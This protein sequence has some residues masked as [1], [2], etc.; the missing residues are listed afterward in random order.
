MRPSPPALIEGLQRIAGGAGGGN[1]TGRTAGPETAVEPMTVPM[2]EDARARF[3]ALGDEITAEL[4][5]AAGT[6]QTPILA[7]IA[8]NAAKVALVLAVGRDAVQPVI[9]LEDAV[10]AI[11]FVRHFARRTIDA[12]ERHVADTETEAHL[13]RLR[14]IIRKAGAAGMTKS[15]LTRASQWLRARDRDDILLTLVE[16]GDIATVEQETGGRKAVRFRAL[17]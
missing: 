16:S 1:L 5:A 9:R 7:R 2:D 6:F 15:E 12:V 3:D 4:R 14:E 17:R 11:E 13:K 8:E 10:W